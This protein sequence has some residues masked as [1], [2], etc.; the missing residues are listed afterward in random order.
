[1]VFVAIIMV[2]LMGM[3]AL[4]IDIGN[5]LH[6]RTKLQSTADATALAAVTQVPSLINVRAEAHQ[7]AQVNEYGDGSVLVDNDVVMGNWNT[8]TRQFTPNGAPANAVHVTVR[9]TQSNNNPVATWFARVIGI[10][11]VDVAADA[12]AATLAGVGSRFL[13][14]DEM[15]D[16]DEP[17]IEDLA[18]Q[19]GMDPID[20]ISDGDGD[21]FI[22]LPV[23]EILELPT[24]QVG[25][26]ALFDFDHPDFP[27][28]QG[29]DPSMEN[30]LNYN[31]D[32]N[33][34]RYNEVPKEMLDPLLGV[35]EVDDESKYPSYVTNQCQVSP[36]Y[37]SDISALNDVDGI[38]AVNA[39]GLRRG[40]LAFKIIAVGA[41]PD[42]GGSKLPNLV[43]QICDPVLD[44]SSVSPGGLARLA[45]VK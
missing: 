40:L 34:W 42:G 45:L 3:A 44:L 25:D 1:M 15:I 14:D 4:S 26:E 32:S 41:D 17:V 11:T 24:G 35:D 38:P 33:S 30:F 9:R 36:V 31:E 7:Y 28:G 37:K 19:Y 10:S 22:D 18:L 6:T 23:G 16:S 21:W 12:I 5:V 43:I 29:T 2:A 13:I 27:F 20:I 39:L 8:G